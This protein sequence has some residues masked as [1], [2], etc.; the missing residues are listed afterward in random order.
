MS[1][2]V[3]KSDEPKR[4]VWAEVYVPGVPDSDG[5]YMNAEDISDMAYAFM[6]DKKND[7][8]DLYHDNVLVK[9]ASIVESFISRKDDPDFPIEGSWVVGVYVGDDPKVWEMIQKNE[10]NGFSIQALVT[11][12]Q[13]ELEIDLPP[14]ISGTTS[15]SE[16]H[17]HEFFVSYDD[18]GKFLGGKTNIVNEHFHT[19][20]RGTVTEESN[21]HSHRFAHIEQLVSA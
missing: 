1:R 17:T 18:E 11:R 6:K 7:Q 9:G 13:A 21:G 16:D 15:K 19:I 20:V 10:I 8:I 12:E 5:D 2:L 14:V 3:I 4:I